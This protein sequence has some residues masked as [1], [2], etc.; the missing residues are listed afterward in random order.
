MDAAKVA[1]VRAQRP[2]ADAKVPTWRA[3]ADE[4]EALLDEL[5]PSGT[6]LSLWGIPIVSD[7]LMPEGRFELRLRGD[8]VYVGILPG[9]KLDES[10][11]K[12]LRLLMDGINEVRRET[13]HQPTEVRIAPAH[14]PQHEDDE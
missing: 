12:A 8:A 11:M 1:A 6:G 13:F 5:A 3:Y 14:D 7:P 10:N 9:R 2:L 4:L